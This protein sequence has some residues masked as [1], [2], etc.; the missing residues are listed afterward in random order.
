MKRRSCLHFF[1]RFRMSDSSAG[2][3]EPGA[4]D[5]GNGMRPLRR[6][7]ERN[8]QRILKAASEV[9]NERG[10]EVSLDEVARHAGVGVGTVYR[11]FRTKEELVEALFVDRIEAVAALAGDAAEAPDPW[12]GLAHFMEQAAEMLAGDSGLRQLLMFA[13]YGGDRVWYARQRNAPVVTKLVERVQAAGQLRSDLGPTD[14]R[15]ILFMLAEAAQF[16]RGVRHEIWRRY[17]TVPFEIAGR[18]PGWS[19]A[20]DGLGLPGRAGVSVWPWRSCATVVAAAGPGGACRP[21]WCGWPRVLGGQLSG[22][23]SAGRRRSRLPVA[24]PGG[25]A[26][27]CRSPPR[28]RGGRWRRPGKLVPAAGRASAQPPTGRCTPGRRP[29]RRAQ[30]SLP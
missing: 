14:I 21:W 28:P 30:R 24:A 6:D 8:R 19:A 20:P 1:G 17:L 29:R 7:A 15:F 13:T 18:G 12:S 11:R 16:G 10:L 9:F 2:P 3:G 22:G 26:H 4:P 25:R 5:G 27:A 23:W